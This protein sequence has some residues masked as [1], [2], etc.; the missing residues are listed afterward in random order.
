MKNSFTARNST[1]RLEVEDPQPRRHQEHNNGKDSVFRTSSLTKSPRVSRSTG[2]LDMLSR[3]SMSPKKTDSTSDRKEKRRE[4]REARQTNRKS[5]LGLG[6]G[7]SSSHHSS[8]GGV[9]RSHSG[10]STDGDDDDMPKKRSSSFQNLNRIMKEHPV[11]NVFEA[12]KASAKDMLLSLNNKTT[13]SQKVKFTTSQKESLKKSKWEE[14]M[15]IIDQLLDRHSETSLYHVMTWDQR[16]KL[17]SVK[18][19]LLEMP[20]KQSGANQ[21]QSMEHIPR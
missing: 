10:C 16:K 11:H 21:A 2:A 9:N 8:R 17:A 1:Y 15:E 20:K 7:G 5:G 18:K 3:L 14:G 13:S 12:A 19:L 4:R 6:L